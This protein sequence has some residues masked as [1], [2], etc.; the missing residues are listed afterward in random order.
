MRSFDI[1][2]GSS[3]ESQTPSIK[4]PELPDASPKWID[5]PEFSLFVPFAW[6]ELPL[7]GGYEFR[8]RVLPQQLI[9]AIHG[10]PV[11]AEQ[12]RTMFDDVVKL[13]LD[14]LRKLSQD[15]AQVR[16][17]Q[18]SETGGCV[19]A[20]FGGRDEAQGVRFEFLVRLSPTKIYN[21]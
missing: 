21:V 9:V 16:P 18:V 11:S 8:N 13:Q 19:D 20:F 4:G 5:K 10:R 12:A 7:Q 17:V 14:T 1:F 15:R 6:D 3:S 2:Q